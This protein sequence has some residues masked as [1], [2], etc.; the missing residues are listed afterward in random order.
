MSGYY[1]ATKILTQRNLN[2]LP[3]TENDIVLIIKSLDWKIKRIDLS[4]QT[5]LTLL[6]K[7]G[8]REKMSEFNALSYFIAD[9]LKIVLLRCE[10][11]AAQSVFALAHELGHIV[12]NHISDS[13]ILG[14]HS[15]Y[16]L[17]NAQEAEANEFARMFT[18]HPLLLKKLKV[19]NICDVHKFV[20]TDDNTAK[21]LL[22]NSKKAG[23]SRN[24]T[25]KTLLNNFKSYIR[26]NAFKRKL[27]YAAIFI[28]LVILCFF[29]GIKNI[30][31]K[32]PDF[33]AVDGN[34][35]VINHKRFNKNCFVCIIKKDNKN[36]HMTDCEYL[37]YYIDTDITQ[38]E[39][40]TLLQACEQGYTPCERCVINRAEWY[41]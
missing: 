37:Y 12:M 17:N 20:F 19:K 28:F 31:P 24:A 8:I 33:Y 10:L 3:I 18:A 40:M 9:K 36:F 34:A 11:S 7:L 26:K 15:D 16:V 4:D 32:Q 29:A 25:E 38:L 23:K 2:T 6:D 5:D 14:F 1:Y 22:H 27:I 30:K 21:I 35:V 39:K 41:E 13:N